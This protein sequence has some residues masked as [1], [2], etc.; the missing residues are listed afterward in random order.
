MRRTSGRV[1]SLIA[2]LILLGTGCR[3]PPSRIAAEAE[4]QAKT[5]NGAELTLPFLLPAEA[6]AETFV[7]RQT[8]T[9]RWVGEDGEAQEASFDAAVQRQGSSLLLLGLGPMGGVGFTLSLEQGK[10]SFENRTGQ[11]LPFA[12][13][14]MLADVQRVYYPWLDDGALWRERSESV[15]GDQSLWRVGPSPPG[16]GSALC[17]DCVRRG[18]R[19]GFDIKEHRRQG[20][21]FRRRFDPLKT[22]LDKEGEAANRPGIE[23]RYSGEPAF[24]GVLR[25]ALLRNEVFGYELELKT[26]SLDWI[27]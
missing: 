6:L 20:Q 22:Q 18:L 26:L 16:E 12:P 27:D 19:G 21:V 15:R 25:D 17:G 10:V 11:D 2:V 23:V 5:R 4:R 3:Q 13:E 14:R 24:G 1:L 8:V 9:V 7:L